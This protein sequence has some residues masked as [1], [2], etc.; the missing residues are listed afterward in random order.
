VRAVHIE[1]SQLLEIL[2][3][4]FIPSERKDVGNMKEAGG[5]RQKTGG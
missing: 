2:C 1:L 4:L 3:D 5:E